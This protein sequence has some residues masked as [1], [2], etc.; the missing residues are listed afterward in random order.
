MM[1]QRALLL[2]ALSISWMLT[3]VE[4]FAN[5]TCPGK[6]EVKD[7]LCKTMQ[8][9]Q[10]ED[11]MKDC[12]TA[13]SSCEKASSECETGKGKEASD[14]AKGESASQGANASS[15]GTQGTSGGA[16]GTQQPNASNMCSGQKT[17]QDRAN[18]GAP[19][20]PAMKKCAK[21]ANKCKDPSGPAAAGKASGNAA[22]NG[23]ENAQRAADAGQMG[24][25][26]D[27]SKQNESKMPQMPQIP[28]MPQQQQQ[29]STPT[30]ST[31]NTDSN[32]NG[33]DTAT[34]TSSALSPEISS[35][36]FGKSPA[37][38]GIVALPIVAPSQ[39]SGSQASGGT[40][41]VGQGLATTSGSAFQSPTSNGSGNGLGSYQ[42][43]GGS[44]GGLGSGS[45]ASLSKSTDGIAGADI[46]PESTAVG[47]YNIGGGKSVLGLKGKAGD[48]EDTPAKLADAGGKDAAAL[49]KALADAKA[50]A[51]AKNKRGTSRSN[52]DKN[53]DGSSLF[54]M[55]RNRYKTLKELG[56][57]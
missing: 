51:D 53:D 39:L 29:S 21:D 56:S 7:D 36:D 10:K 45:G 48:D 33:S 32:L 28:Q 42:S 25:K 31:I 37:N 30:D 8:S 55:V 50:A 38:G 5:L 57:I 27:Q 16:G 6:L 19:I 4:A 49:A 47:E 2:S 11:C 26:C 18:D 46:K 14:I 54:T 20:P 41:G 43:G 12:A 44:S 40:N 9:P 34:N 15:D 52:A 22:S 35:V 23:A 24:Q 13:K 3:S 1:R 17:N